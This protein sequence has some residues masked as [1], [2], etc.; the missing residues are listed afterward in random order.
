MQVS[1]VY[2]FTRGGYLIRVRYEIRNNGAIPLAASAYHYRLLR[3]GK[4]PEGEKPHGSHLS[5][6]AV[7]TETDKFQKVKFEDIDKNK[8]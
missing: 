2:T 5:G 4:A 8:G 7:Y 1:K 3:D 6:P